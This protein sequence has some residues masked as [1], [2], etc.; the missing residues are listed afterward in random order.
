M[1]TLKVYD[2]I[3]E[4]IE[5]IY[6]TQWERNNNITIVSKEIVNKLSNDDLKVIEVGK[7]NGEIGLVIGLKVSKRTGGWQKVYPYET[8]VEKFPDIYNYYKVI[9]NQNRK[10]WEA[11]RNETNKN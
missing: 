3:E 10:I 11:R 7:S 4:L 9:D 8:V 1:R 5:S 2:T 6:R